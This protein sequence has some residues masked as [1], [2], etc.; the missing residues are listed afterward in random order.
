[1]KTYE[2]VVESPENLFELEGSDVIGAYLKRMKVKRR[3]DEKAEAEK[4]VERAEK[5]GQLVDPIPPGSI[6]SWLSMKV[7]EGVPINAGK[8]DATKMGDWLNYVVVIGKPT[9]ETLQAV[10]YVLRERGVQKTSDC[11]WGSQQVFRADIP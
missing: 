7:P 6:G 10:H 3:A 5:V 11:L 8:L 2:G 1:M 9:K 4:V